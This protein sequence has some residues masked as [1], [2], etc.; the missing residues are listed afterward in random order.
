MEKRGNFHDVE[1]NTPREA[2]APRQ[3][4]NKQG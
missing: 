2:P 1:P 3:Y 4:I